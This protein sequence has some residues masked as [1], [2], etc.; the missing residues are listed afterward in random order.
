MEWNLFTFE[1]VLN[2]PKIEVNKYTDKDYREYIKKQFKADYYNQMFFNIVLDSEFSGHDDFKYSI[3]PKEQLIFFKELYSSFTYHFQND[4]ITIF[5]LKHK[6]DNAP[7]DYSVF[8]AVKDDFIIEF[9]RI[10]DLL[11]EKLCAPA[12][13]IWW[14][15]ADGTRADSKK[16]EYNTKGQQNYLTF[17]NEEE[18]QQWID[19]VKNGNEI[20]NP[21]P[22]LKEYSFNEW[23]RDR[24][25]YYFFYKLKIHKYGERRA[26][27]A[28]NKRII[29]SFTDYE[30]TMLQMI[31][32]FSQE[33]RAV[34]I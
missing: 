34:M 14:Y 26:F 9:P 7:D 3:E 2:K 32:Y 5:S 27:L 24:R 23:W 19:F 11:K 28:K 1:D 25:E 33:Q 18:K 22:N 10:Q 29:D 30:F 8:V 20:I 6:Y 12:C 17:H 13:A 21:N 4:L 31:N 15:N 16:Y